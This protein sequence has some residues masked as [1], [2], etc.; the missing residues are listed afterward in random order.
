MSKFTINIP[1]DNAKSTE[2]AAKASASMRS[3]TSFHIDL[4]ER[5]DTPMLIKKIPANLAP[6]VREQL[7][8]EA[9]ERAEEQKS[10]KHGRDDDSDDEFYPKRT[11][12]QTPLPGEREG[13]YLIF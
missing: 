1:A 4:P 6:L 3:Q 11:M 9:S 13:H 7:R 5:K 12:P 8:R 10:L 2:N